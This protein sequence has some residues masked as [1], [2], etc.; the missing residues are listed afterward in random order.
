MAMG[1]KGS[2]GRP[3]R[4]APPRTLLLGVKLNHVEK[5]AVAK[6]ADQFAM[7]QAD[8]VRSVLRVA[9]HGAWPAAAAARLTVAADARHG[10]A[11]RRRDAVA[12]HPHSRTA[13]E[14]HP[15]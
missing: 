12:P 11:H 14:D 4:S 7:P 15:L 8:W 6:A 5:A 2:K 3:A 10:L 1:I 13:H 9:G